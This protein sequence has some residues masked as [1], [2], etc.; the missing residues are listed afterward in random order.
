MQCR[1]VYI[2]MRNKLAGAWNPNVENTRGRSMKVKGGDSEWTCIW[3][4]GV[5]E[6][7]AVVFRK[8]SE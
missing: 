5:D 2:K 7:S 1:F 8:L 3:E 6:G 4:I